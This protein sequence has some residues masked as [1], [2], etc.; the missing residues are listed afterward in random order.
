MTDIQQIKCPKCEGTETSTRYL[1]GCVPKSAK[2][3]TTSESRQ[4]RRKPF[5]WYEEARTDVESSTGT[6]KE[7]LPILRPCPRCGEETPGFRVI[8][9]CGHGYFPRYEKSA[10]A[11]I[12]ATE[13]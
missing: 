12:P 3:D 10:A 13:D 1:H 5:S 11:T 4:L 6:S 8:C 7:P 9:T 2:N